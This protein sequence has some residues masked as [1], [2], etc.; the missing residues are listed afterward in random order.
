[1]RILILSCSTGDGH[2]SAARA[3]TEAAARRGVYAELRDPVSFSGERARRAVAELYNGMIR[4]TP[5]LFGAVYRVGDVVGR[6]PLPSPIYAANSL[7]AAKLG[8][9][10]RDGGFDAVISTHL[11]GMEAMTAAK[12]KGICSVPN[13]GVLT[14]YTYIPFFT[15]PELDAAFLPHEDMIREGVKMGLAEEK[16]I[17]AGIPVSGRFGE[18]ISAS[19]ARKKLDAENVRRLYLLMSG[20]VGC[21]NMKKICAALVRIVGAG[22]RIVVI[23]GRNGRM[24]AQIDERWR[25]NP[26]VRTVGFTT[27]VPLWM[28]A[29]DVTVS[30]AGGLSSTEAAVAGTP[31][32]HLMTIPGCETKN[33]EF[34]SARG[35]SIRTKDIGEAARAAAMLAND[36]KAAD[37]MRK[38]QAENAHA[39]AADRVIGYVSGDRN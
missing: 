6:S 24:K 32:V 29:A 25:G 16:L 26:A 9:Y 38:A 4:R 33:A 34:F 7:Y 39:D 20:G 17:P 27:D 30:K 28:K 8:A 35:M 12:R 10:V 18:R 37:R 14:D 11:Y 23:T 3:L 15:E 36:R 19:E 21:V 31:L 2:N 1:V 13:Y 22:D 5:R